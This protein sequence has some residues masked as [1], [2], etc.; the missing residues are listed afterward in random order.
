[1]RL[2]CSHRSDAKTT[3]SYFTAH[4]NFSARRRPEQSDINPPRN[5]PQIIKLCVCNESVIPILENTPKKHITLRRFG[6]TKVATALRQV[7]SPGALRRGVTPACGVVLPAGPRLH[8]RAE[9]LWEGCVVH[10]GSRARPV[11]RE[12][13]HPTLARPIGLLPR[14]SSHFNRPQT[15]QTSLPVSF[16]HLAIAFCTA[17]LEMPTLYLYTCVLHLY[18]A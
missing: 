18:A 17:R 12:V 3:T 6:P 1:M 5:H 9:P 16:G 11:P 13:S 2:G 8:P 15:H 7:S 10:Q 14:R 4:Q